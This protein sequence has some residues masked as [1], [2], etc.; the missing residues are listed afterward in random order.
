MDEHYE[1]E[2]VGQVRVGTKLELWQGGRPAGWGEVT[3]LRPERQV[4]I[5]RLDEDETYVAGVEGD[6]EDI[7]VDDW[8]PQV[9]A[10]MQERER[11]DTEPAAV[12]HY[13]VEGVGQVRVGTKLEVWDGTQDDEDLDWGEVTKLLVDRR[14]EVHWYGEDD[15]SICEIEDVVN[16][17]VDDWS[18][19]IY[20]TLRKRAAGQGHGT[21]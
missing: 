3:E 7:Y 21:A 1:V 8:S 15:R 14:V 10:L 19:E 16:L 5:R 13:E 11:R 6:G 20:D 9:R 4:V 12:T 17:F 18:P 2:G